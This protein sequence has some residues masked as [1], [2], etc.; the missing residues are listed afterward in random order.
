MISHGSLL[1]INEGAAA[2]LRAARLTPSDAGHVADAFTGRSDPTRLN[3]ALSLRGDQELCVCDLAW[4]A[5]RPQNLVSHHMRTLKVD[6]LV[7]S[8]RQGK[9][10]MYSLTPV[11]RTLADTAAALSPA[12]GPRYR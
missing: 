7:T 8:R 11:G 6:G 5:E 3:L 12:G 4:I 9:M 1:H 2:R 10:T